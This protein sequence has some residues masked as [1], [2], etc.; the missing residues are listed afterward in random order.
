VFSAVSAIIQVFGRAKKP[1]F[2]G[3]VTGVKEGGCLI[4][5]G[6]NYYKAGIATG[7]IVADIL[8]GKKP[9]DI[10]VKFL[11]EPSESDLMFDLDNA[12]LLGI[13]IPPKYLSQANLIFE[14]G[15][16]TER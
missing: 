1:I 9:A 15:K 12:K 16:L 5:S 14:N 8:E 6:F 7:N 3:D 13:T 10:P 2:A 4:A 11:T